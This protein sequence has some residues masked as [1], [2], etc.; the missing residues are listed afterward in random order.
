MGS[1][2]P[3]RK[4]ELVRAETK[5]DLGALLGDGQYR[6][7][8]ELAVPAPSNGDG[9]AP[10]ETRTKL[11]LDVDSIQ[12]WIRRRVEWKRLDKYELQFRM[13]E[14]WTRPGPSRFS[15]YRR[16]GSSRG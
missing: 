1:A 2:S 5:A 7:C 8:L 6:P 12:L 3:E 16:S 14:E 9:A 13:R 4:G 15:S 11:F 10:S